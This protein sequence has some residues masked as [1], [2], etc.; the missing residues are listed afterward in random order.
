MRLVAL[1]IVVAGGIFATATTSTSVGQSAAACGSRLRA[2][3]TLSDPGRRLIY[4]RPRPTTIA[5]VNARAMPGRTP[6]W[7]SRGYARH[8]WE[9]VAQIVEYKLEAD[10]DIH[11]ILFDGGDYMI[12]KLPSPACVPKRSRDRRRDRLGPAHLRVELRTGY[13]PL[14][15][16]RSGRV[17]YW[18]RLLG[19]P[20]RPA[21][22]RTQLRRAASPHG[23]PHHRRV[24]LVGREDRCNRCGDA[25][26]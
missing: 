15:I 7:R 8:V 13:E 21:W 6:T 11:L 18:R 14:A 12:A 10:G 5:E 23:D 9:L 22:P 2:L 19:L 4:L 16:P 20:A 3:K 26:L 24:L 1:C 25:V 17:H